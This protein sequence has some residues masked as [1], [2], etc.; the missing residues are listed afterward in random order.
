MGHE[1]WTHLYMHAFCIVIWWRLFLH[2]AEGRAG[3]SPVGYWE[4][5]RLDWIMD[6]SMINNCIMSRWGFTVSQV[7]NE[8]LFDIGPETLR[9]SKP[10]VM[11]IAD[12]H[13]VAQ[14]DI[15]M[16][17]VYHNSW[18]LSSSQQSMLPWGNEMGRLCLERWF[19]P[20]QGKTPIRDNKL[21]SK[22]KGIYSVS[23]TTKSNVSFRCHV[24]TNVSFS[25]ILHQVF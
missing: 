2:W 21:R 16:V 1:I 22:S 7:M 17:T 23:N 15:Q 24:E 14:R 10:G 3:E 12:E 25:P 20:P 4:T 5:C 11:V 9:V 19:I 13:W 18:L 6:I 8:C